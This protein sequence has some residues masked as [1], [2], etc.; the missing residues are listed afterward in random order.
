MLSQMIYIKTT[1]EIH[2]N[3]ITYT[4]LPSTPFT[5]KLHETPTNQRILISVS[6]IPGSGKTTLAA[7]VVNRLN[8]L[9]H[10]EGNDTDIAAMIPMVTDLSLSPAYLSS[11]N[12]LYL[13]WVPLN[14]CCPLCHAKPARSPRAS[15]S[16]IHL[17]PRSA[18]ETRAEVKGVY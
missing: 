7:K 9:H 15:R 10:S 3:Q 17:R 12:Y 6:G 11:S 8:A 4:N 13:G 18:Q 14:P 16:T 2:K 5:G 1:A